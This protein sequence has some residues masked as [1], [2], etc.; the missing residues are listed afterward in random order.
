MLDRQ[1]ALAALAQL[2]DFV[3]SSGAPAPKAPPPSSRKGPP[4][5]EFL[6]AIGYTRIYRYENAIIFMGG[7]QI[8]A[9]GGPHAYHPSGGAGLDVLANAGHPG[10]WW[11]IAT[12]NGKPGGT[13]V[14]QG[15]NDPAPGFYVSTTALEDTRFSEKAQRRYVDAETV[16]FIV[17][18]DRFGMGVRLGDLGFAYNTLGVDSE[19]FIYADT[20]PHGQIG[21]GSIALAKSLKVPDSPRTGGVTAGIVYVIFPGSGSGYQEVSEWKPVAEKLAINF[22][23]LTKVMDLVS[24]L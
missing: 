12:S 18:P 24:Q 20:G 10:N 6:L 22:G 4:A 3:K 16:P 1:Q 17:L 13:P 8:D 2:E 5:L 7:M 14:L 9:D 11:G 23:G 19:F 21:E 15:E